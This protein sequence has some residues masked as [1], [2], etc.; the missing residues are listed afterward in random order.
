MSKIVC[1]ST[2]DHGHSAARDQAAPPPA[3]TNFPWRILVVDKS[4]DLRLLYADALSSP[5]CRVDAAEHG[6][7]AWAALQARHYHL[8]ITENELPDLAGNKLLEKLHSARKDLPSV[9]FVESLPAR[10][11]AQ[12]PSLPRTPTLLKPFALEALL[13]AVKNALSAAIPIGQPPSCLPATLDAT[14]A[15]PPR[16]FLLADPDQ[17][18]GPD[19]LTLSVR[20]R[21]EF[22]QNGESFGKLKRGQ[23]LAQGDI[24]RTGL[25]SRTDLFLR[26]TGT[27]VRLQAATE[28]RLEK[29]DLTFQDGQPL[30][31]TLLALHAGR[32]LTVVRFTV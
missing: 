28:V 6:A 15:E 13:D 16:P 12:N 23:V 26:R 22:S 3:R 21:C 27:S 9:I 19:A 20:G 1:P 32:L 5:A 14:Q 7:S 2:H 18:A 30:A 31:H 4:S 11:P 8:L 25:N 17:A 29:M 24:I 10:E